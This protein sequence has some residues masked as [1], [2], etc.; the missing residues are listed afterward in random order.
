MTFTF[1]KGLVVVTG[2]P[3]A[4]L[5][6]LAVIVMKQ[7][8]FDGNAFILFLGIAFFL[9]MGL[10]GCILTLDLRVDE[11]GISK[12]FL[13]KKVLFLKWMDVKVIKDVEVKSL[14]GQLHRSF[15]VLPRESASLS[16]WSG[17]W[18]RFPDLMRDFPTFVNEI[19]KYVRA[20]NVK[21]ERIRNAKVVICDEISVRDE[22]AFKLPGSV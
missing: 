21:I 7:T 9:T 18:I 3:L 6:F 12:L 14:A 16:F 2:I 10:I 8:G 20:N 22:Q 1:R 5:A 13:Q 17:G 4:V 15:Y 19:N 11:Q